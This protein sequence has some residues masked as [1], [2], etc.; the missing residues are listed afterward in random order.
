MEA[1]NLF[2]ENLHS[3]SFLVITGSNLSLNSEDSPQSGTSIRRSSSM[4][5]GSPFS[6]KVQSNL[7]KTILLHIHLSFQ[8]GSSSL[9]RSSMSRPSGRPSGLPLP[10]DSLTPRK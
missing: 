9:G 4:R 3:R 7:Q 10:S 6:L 8:G 2:R 5:S 1:N